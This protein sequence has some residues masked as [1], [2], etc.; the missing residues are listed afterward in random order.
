MKLTLISTF[1]LL[2]LLVKPAISQTS[3][4]FAD[5]PKASDFLGS[6]TEFVDQVEDAVM[7]VLIQ[8]F[9][10]VAAIYSLAQLI[11]AMKGPR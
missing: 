7:P 11:K 10:G 2:G 6:P 3:N 4:P 9:S 8:F 1:L 5:I